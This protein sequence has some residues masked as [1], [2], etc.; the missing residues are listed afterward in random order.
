MAQEQTVSLEQKRPWYYSTW[1]LAL[2]FILGWPVIQF[3]IGLPVP[4][5]WP[6]WSILILRSPWHRNFILAPWPGQC[7]CPGDSWS[8]FSFCRRILSST[9]CSPGSSS[10]RDCCWRHIPNF[11][12]LVT[13]GALAQAGSERRQA[14]PRAKSLPGSGRPDR[15]GGRGGEGPGPAGLPATPSKSRTP[16]RVSHLALDL[17]KADSGQGFGHGLSVLIFHH[18]LASHHPPVSFLPFIHH[19]SS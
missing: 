2:T 13:G 15:S 8:Y 18:H 1:F 10:R 14:P 16:I 17:R 6:A 12:G 4:L 7:L 3:S 5:L 19:P 11:F 9:R